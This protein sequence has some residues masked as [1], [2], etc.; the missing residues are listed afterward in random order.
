MVLKE[1][2]MKSITAKCVGCGVKRE[3]KEGEI[4]S[5]GCPMCNVCGMP[6]VAVSAKITKGEGNE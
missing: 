4:P 1:R 6:M 3:I 5:D 2:K